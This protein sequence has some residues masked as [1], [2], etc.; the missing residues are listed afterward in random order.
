MSDNGR[1]YIADMAG[2]LERAE[3]TIRQ[4]LGR[5]DFPRALE[6]QREGGRNKIFWTEDQLGGM[7]A[8]ADERERQRGSWGRASA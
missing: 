5:S 2:Q 8:Y 3:H 1:I 7:R 6:P 4:W